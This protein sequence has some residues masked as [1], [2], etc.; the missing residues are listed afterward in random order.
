MGHIRLYLVTC[1]ISI[2]SRSASLRT[3]KEQW[4]TALELKPSGAS[5]LSTPLALYCIV[6]Y[7]ISIVFIAIVVIV[8][9]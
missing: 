7:M 8:F 5:N 6:V 9:F 4:M 1:K 2:S 3:A